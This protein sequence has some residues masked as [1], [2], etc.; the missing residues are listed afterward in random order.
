MIDKKYLDKLKKE[1]YIAWDELV[2][3]VY[4]I[5]EDKSLFASPVI[6]AFILFGI[7]VTLIFFNA[8]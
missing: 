2:N 5:G 4:I 1:D 7:V 8:T 3:D 6:I